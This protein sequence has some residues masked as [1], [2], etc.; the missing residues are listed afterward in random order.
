MNQV[1]IAVTITGA[2]DNVDV[3]DLVALADRFEFVEWGILISPKRHGTSRY[4]TV[5]WLNALRDVCLRDNPQPLRLAAHFCGAAARDTIAGDP[6]H[7]DA[8]YMDAFRRVQLNGYM[9]VR[10]GSEHFGAGA[11]RKFV[12]ER[13]RWVEFILQ[14]QSVDDAHEAALD[15]RNIGRATVLYDPSGGRGIYPGET[16]GGGWPTV[17]L[18]F[19]VSMGF[20]GGIGPDNV[21][22]VLAAVGHHKGMWIDM[23]SGVRDAEDN[24]DLNRVEDV[25]KKV[26]HAFATGV[27]SR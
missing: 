27:I 24:F 8:P 18:P 11:L 1:H 21:A 19:N 22:E 16:G 10:T 26:S 17:P 9:A 12:N 15:A 25:L 20:A 5:E 14:A 3:M 4:P 13:D 2:D 7:I 6:Q 23:E